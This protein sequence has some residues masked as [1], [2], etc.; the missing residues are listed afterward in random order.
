MTVVNKFKLIYLS[1]N[2]DCWQATDDLLKIWFCTSFQNQKYNIF[3]IIEHEKK[4]ELSYD[5]SLKIKK[6]KKKEKK[7]I[8]KTK[9]NKEKEKSTVKKK[10]T[11]IL[12]WDIL[13][14][15]TSDFQSAFWKHF[16]F[17]FFVISESLSSSDSLLESVVFY[18]TRQKHELNEKN[19][20]WIAQYN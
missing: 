3:I 8:I 2:A 18:H 19:L 5:Q 7:S 1:Q 10:K 17:D 9:K 14:T 16:F 4:N 12:I 6:E 15:E 13:I 11:E 20:K